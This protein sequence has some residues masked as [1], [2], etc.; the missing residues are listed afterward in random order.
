M[1]LPIPTH[2]KKILSLMGDEN[3]EFEVS[4]HLI[5]IKFER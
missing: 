2:L 3:N 1:D 4:H 5:S